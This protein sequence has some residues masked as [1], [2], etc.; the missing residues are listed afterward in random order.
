MNEVVD[1]ITVVDLIATAPA[2]LMLQ[3]QANTPGKDSGE[4]DDDVDIDP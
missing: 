1:T 4:G 3:F 2:V